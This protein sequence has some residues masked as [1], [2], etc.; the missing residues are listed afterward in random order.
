[1]RQGLT[2]IVLHT[3]IVDYTSGYGISRTAYCALSAIPGMQ[4]S[5]SIPTKNLDAAVRLSILSLVDVSPMRSF[6]NK[7]ES[8]FSIRALPQ[9]KMSDLRQISLTSRN[10]KGNVYDPRK[11]RGRVFSRGRTLKLLLLA[12][13][14]RRRAQTLNHA[15][16]QPIPNRKSDPKS[17]SFP[18]P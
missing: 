5:T 14:F 8:L 10:A 3:E 12:K 6:P 7:S 2:E 16:P 9:L 15:R 13:L 11:L 18:C 17:H 4:L 1:M